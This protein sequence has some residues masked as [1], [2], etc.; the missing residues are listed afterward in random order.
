MQLEIITP[1][2]TLY[3][4]DADSVTFPGTNGKFQ[5]LK[6]HAPII[7]SLNKGIVIVKNG[8]KTEQFEIEGGV[9]EVLSNKIVVLV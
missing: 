2:K 4:G 6:N 7:T 5:I 9:V 8:N 3:N 1:D